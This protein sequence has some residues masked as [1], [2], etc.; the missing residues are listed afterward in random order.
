MEFYKT[1]C[2]YLKAC[3]IEFS[4]SFFRLR[5]Q[6]HPD[7]PSLLSFTDTL[8]EIGL[9][10]SAVVSDKERYKELRYPLLAHAINKSR[11]DFVVVTESS[12]FD[13]DNSM[14]LQKWDNIVLMIDEGGV[15][16]Y[17]EHKEWRIKETNQRKRF[18]IVISLVI[19]IAALINSYHL[20]VTFISLTLLSLMGI[21]VSGLIIFHS[22]GKDNA[23]TEQ[24]CNTDVSQGCDKILKSKAAMVWKDFGLG[25]IGIVYFSGISL[26]ILI[27][28]L[29][30]TVNE[31]C[32]IL[33]MPFTLG[34]FFCA[35]SVYYQWHI[36][37]NWCR[38]CLFVVSIVLLQ[39]G[40]LFYYYLAIG[41]IQF[42]TFNLVL[43]FSALCMPAGSWFLLKPIVLRADAAFA[44]E[45]SVLKWK[46]D[47]D[48]FLSLLYGQRFIEITPWEDD[49]KFGNPLASFQ[50]MIACNPY[51]KP[52]ASTHKIIEELL[53]ANGESIGVTIRFALQTTN[54]EDKNKLAV[55]HIIEALQPRSNHDALSVVD[56]WFVWMDLAM[57]KEKYNTVVDTE[58]LRILLNKHICWSRESKITHTPTIII[59]GHEMPKCYK[60]TDLGLILIHLIENIALPFTVAKVI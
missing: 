15:I 10:Y 41:V 13:A 55:M 50:I 37:K 8:D 24:L 16:N 14:L 9:P 28:G 19:S 31:S 17:S 44:A 20:S 32:T 54:V 60:I 36:A 46:R 52:C 48:V 59:N 42:S 7:Y 53:N 27:S 12:A 4:E 45:I 49:I 26:F 56:D 57:F 5:M 40:M 11:E 58:K 34:V 47:P 30:N 1:A 6:S 43:F 33:I 22:M 23:L 21:A 2:R 25:D 18:Y 3:Q 39:A 38:M 51:C 29:T 35:F